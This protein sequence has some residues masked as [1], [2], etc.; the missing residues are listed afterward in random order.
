M[1]DFVV[2]GICWVEIKCTE[3]TGGVLWN[4]NG[5]WNMAANETICKQEWSISLVAIL[6]LWCFISQQPT[7]PNTMQGRRIY[8]KCWPFSSLWNA[9][10]MY[11]FCVSICKTHS[12]LSLFQKCSRF[13]SQI[14]C[15]SGSYLGEKTTTRLSCILHVTLI[16]H[17]FVIISLL[18]G[19]LF[20]WQK[21]TL[22]MTQLSTRTHHCH[23]VSSCDIIYMHTTYFYALVDYVWWQCTSNVT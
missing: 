22:K 16:C 14:C 21:L 15:L 4:Q 19:T 9:L 3:L 20:L 8:C 5:Y 1:H 2:V 17:T 23:T 6:I 13:C 10:C 11:I 7:M 12:S 18:Q